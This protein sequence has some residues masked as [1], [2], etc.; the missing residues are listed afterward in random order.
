MSKKWT[1]YAVEQ[2]CSLELRDGE[3]IEEHLD[4]IRR[5]LL[6]ARPNTKLLLV[7]APDGHSVPMQVAE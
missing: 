3:T 1:V 2:E 7:V 6:A 5:A 4:V